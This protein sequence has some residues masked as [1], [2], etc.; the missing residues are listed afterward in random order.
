MS[1]SLARPST[2][3]AW[4]RIFNAPRDFADDFIFA[5]AGLY[6]HGKNDRACGEI[7]RDLE[8]SI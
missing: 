7:F 4:R 1:A 8:H 6:T 3:G 5:G 2:A